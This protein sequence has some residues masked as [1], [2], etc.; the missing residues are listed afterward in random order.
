M[1]SSMVD[2]YAQVAARTQTNLLS[3]F[4]PQVTLVPE[5]GFSSVINPASQKNFKEQTS[6]SVRVYSFKKVGGGGFWEREIPLL[7]GV[8]YDGDPVMAIINDPQRKSPHPMHYITDP[9]LYTQMVKF[10]WSLV[11]LED[12][13]DTSNEVYKL[14]AEG[15][16]G[17]ISKQPE[18]VQ[19]EEF[20]LIRFNRAVDFLMAQVN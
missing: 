9:E 1:F 15:Y 13:G 20:N 7:M 12:Q 2:F 10:M 17:G 4:T 8:F 18:E 19:H 14:F 11:V 16:S 6:V 3:F 5:L